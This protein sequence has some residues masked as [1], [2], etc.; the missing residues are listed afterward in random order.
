MPGVMADLISFTPLGKE[1][2]NLRV[3]PQIRLRTFSGLLIEV[4]G[5]SPLWVAPSLGL[6]A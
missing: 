1:N 6:W 4:G 2:F 5:P 3:V